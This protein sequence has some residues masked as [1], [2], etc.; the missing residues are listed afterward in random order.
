MHEYGGDM[1]QLATR[2]PKRLH[3]ALRLLAIEEG[4]SVMAFVSEALAEHLERCQQ[5]RGARRERP[6]SR[7]KCVVSSA[8]PRSIATGPNALQR[9]GEP[10]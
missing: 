6:A 1:I 7:G 8:G 3:R 10:T 9:R 4:T 5:G 2:I